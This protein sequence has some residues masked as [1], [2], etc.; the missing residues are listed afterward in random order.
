MQLRVLKRDEQGTG[1]SRR[2]RRSGF[3]PVII[4]GNGMPQ[5]GKVD[6]NFLFHALKKEVFHSSILDLEIDGESQRV[7]LRNVQYH[8][9]RKIIL[10]ADFLRVEKDKVLD[11]RVPLHFINEDISPAVKLNGAIVNHIVSDL[12]IVCLPK[13]LPEF[14]EI[15]LSQFEASHTIHAKDIKLPL[16]VELT[17]S[18]EQEN[19]VLVSAVVPSEM[20]EDSD[21]VE[22]SDA[23]SSEEK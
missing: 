4:Y 20:K 19:P 21:T 18:L 2:L 8:P 13:D 23:S 3:T 17:P 1:A 16:G 10:H 11:T 9:F 12:H 22:V 6:H 14:I 15:D 5:K 7:L